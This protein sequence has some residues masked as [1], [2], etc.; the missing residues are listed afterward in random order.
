M[1]N[2]YVKRPLTRERYRSRPA[3]PHLDAFILWLEQRGYQPRRI[4]RLIR[5]VHRFSQWAQ[6]NGLGVEELDAKALAQFRDHLQGRQPLRYPSG[7]YR[8]VILGARHFVTFLETLGLVSPTAV[9]LPSPP[10]PELLGAFRQWMRTH[11]GTTEATLTTYRLPILELL[12]TLGEQPA[13]F[14]A[15]ALRTFL[16]ERAGRRGIAQAKKLV[17]AVRMFLRFLIATGQCAPGLE[18]ALPTIAH[19]RLAALPKYLPP[20]MVEHVLARCDRATPLGTRDRAVL[21]LLARLGLRAGDVAALQWDDIDWPDGTLRVAGK[22]RR[23]TRLPLPQEVGEAILYYGEHHRPDVPSPYV[24][25]TTIA[26]LGPLSA[27]TVTKIAAR[28]LRRADVESPI[29]GAHVFRHSVATTMLRQGVSLPSIGALLRHA[30]I[31]T[32]AI[33]AKVDTPLLHTVVRAWPEVPSC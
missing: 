14:E 21:L 24:F 30:S 16:L 3:G 8:P 9:V 25:L 19:W 13:Y 15:K 31:E 32:T 7:S 5:G 11:R 27:K 4:L 28:A 20:E 26:P 23:A 6:E 12:H 2:A 17:Q 18:H 1:L 29:Y 10:E 33:Y 22:N